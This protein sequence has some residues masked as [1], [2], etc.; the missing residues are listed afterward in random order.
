MLLRGNHGFAMIL[1]LQ[2]FLVPLPIMQS[3]TNQDAG[4]GF[5]HF[6]FVGF[7]IHVKSP[8]QAKPIN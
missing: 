5:L 3:I 6:C 1:P 7:A 8:R 2:A 4:F